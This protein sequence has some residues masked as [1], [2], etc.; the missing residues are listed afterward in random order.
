MASFPVVG[1]FAGEWGRFAADSPRPDAR[2]SASRSANQPGNVCEPP[3]PGR[4]GS[5][6]PKEEATRNSQ[7]WALVPRSLAPNKVDCDFPRVREM[8]GAVFDRCVDGVFAGEW[9]RFAADS[10]RPDARGSASRSAN[11]PGNVCEPPN[12]GRGGS[13]G[14]KEEATR[15]SPTRSASSKS[16]ARVRGDD[17]GGTRR[18]QMSGGDMNELTR[19]DWNFGWNIY[20]LTRWMRGC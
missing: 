12:P 8:E 7:A 1:V 17:S 13:P 11:Q 10:P 15:N 14:P 4:G 3:N 9:G 20:S 2:G 16:A 18:P 5:P 6:G 19:Y